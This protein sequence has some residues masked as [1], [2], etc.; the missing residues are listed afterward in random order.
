MPY[1][2]FFCLVWFGFVL[3]QKFL[4]QGLDLNDS[5]NNTKSLTVRL[6]GNLTFFTHYIFTPLRKM[7]LLSVASMLAPPIYSTGLFTMKRAAGGP[8]MVSPIPGKQGL[9]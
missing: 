6:S 8:S 9:K 4:S 3:I 2:G 5:S 7:W 1:P